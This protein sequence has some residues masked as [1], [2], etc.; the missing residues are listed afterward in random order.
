MSS[1]GETIGESMAM[2]LQLLV[3][4]RQGKRGGLGWVTERSLQF[5][6]SSGEVLDAA[7]S[8]R[9]TSFRLARPASVGAGEECV[10]RVKPGSTPEDPVT[11]IARTLRV[12]GR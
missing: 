4:S 2:F 10:G 7:E 12:L 11:A 8:D 6:R 5:A 1:A 9:R 3:Y